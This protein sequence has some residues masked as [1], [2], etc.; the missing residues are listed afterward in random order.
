MVKGGRKMRLDMFE[1]LVLIFHSKVI[2]FAVLLLTFLIYS[3]KYDISHE[4]MLVFLMGFSLWFAFYFEM[5]WL[6]IPALLIIIYLSITKFTKHT[7]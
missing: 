4:T 2:L 5:M 6:I 1:N 7:R 3:L